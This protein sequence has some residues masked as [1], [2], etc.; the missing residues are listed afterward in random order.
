MDEKEIKAL[1]H[2]NTQEGKIEQKIEKLEYSMDFGEYTIQY[3]FS[4]N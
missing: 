2:K 1:I 4:L 3:D